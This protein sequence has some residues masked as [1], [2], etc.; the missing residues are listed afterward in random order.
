VN[1]TINVVGNATFQYVSIGRDLLVGGSTFIGSSISTG[2]GLFSADLTISTVESKGSAIL[3]GNVYVS[4]AVIV[5]QLVVGQDTVLYGLH[6]NPF[7]FNTLTVTS[8]LSTPILNVSTMLS[9]GYLYITNSNYPINTSTFY[10]STL[11]TPQVSTLSSFTTQILNGNTF[12][13]ITS[14]SPTQFQNPYN[15]LISSSTYFIQGISSMFLSTGS[16]KASTIRG[17]FFGDAT[18]ISNIT[19]AVADNAIF[20][21]FITSSLSSINIY[22]SSFSLQ[23]LTTRTLDFYSSLNTSQF[24]IDAPGA[25]ILS[26]IHQIVNITRSSLVI[27]NV[28]YLNKTSNVLISPILR[29]PSNY[30]LDISGLLYVSS[31]HYSS[32]QILDVNQLS[33][34]SVTGTTSS[35]IV[36]N[37]LE[38]NNLQLQKGTSSFLIQNTNT[39]TSNAFDS[40]QATP[41]SLVFENQLSIQNE[42]FYPN[43]K[44]IIDTTQANFTTAANSMMNVYGQI[45]TSTLKTSTLTVGGQI[46]TPNLFFSTFAIY[47]GNAYQELKIRNSFQSYNSTLSM[48]ST[49]FLHKTHNVLGINTSPDPSTFMRVS[50]NA[51]FSTLVAS[52]LRAGSLSYSFQTL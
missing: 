8:V 29:Q 26:T 37:L 12:S 24:R 13:L 44:I 51:F 41:S 40:I 14:P 19:T 6:N 38:L 43:Q 52:D 21:T 15:F 22:T 34:N 17:A 5:D 9:T 16:V 33:N 7:F 36:A 20:S 31:L 10:A 32:I 49:L 4:S 18:Y 46:S 30:S 35:L 47:N 48:N 45:L 2:S 50:S 23:T 3:S 28:L 42:L 25:P 11:L 39:V 1:D 27:N